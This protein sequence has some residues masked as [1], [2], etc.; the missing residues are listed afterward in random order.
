MIKDNQVKV[1]DCSFGDSSPDSSPDPEPFSMNLISMTMTS[2]NV[3]WLKWS[4]DHILFFVIATDSVLLHVRLLLLDYNAE[5]KKV[6]GT[7][8]NPWDL[9]LLSE[10]LDWW[11]A[12]ETR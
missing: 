5:E 11:W 3:I 9:P 12:A 2:W 1:G 10:C 8:P 4:S 7:I 6:S